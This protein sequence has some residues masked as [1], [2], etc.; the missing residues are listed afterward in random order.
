MSIFEECQPP[1]FRVA[2]EP[3]FTGSKPL[4][5]DVTVTTTRGDGSKQTFTFVAFSEAGVDAVMQSSI[6][7]P[8]PHEFHADLCLG[9]GVGVAAGGKLY[10]VEFV[11]VNYESRP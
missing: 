2:F 9:T 3:D 1:H 11:E 5:A 4:P 7:I 6:E 8:E 10:P